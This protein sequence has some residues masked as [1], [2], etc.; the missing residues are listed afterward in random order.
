MHTTRDDRWHDH[1]QAT[2]PSTRQAAHQA[3]RRCET[4]RVVL[5]DAP[6]PWCHPVASDL[7]GDLRAQRGGHPV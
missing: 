5:H 7:V 1:R 3:G 4:C 2:R 6:C